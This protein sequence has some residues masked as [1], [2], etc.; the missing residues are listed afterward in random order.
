MNYK[1]LDGLAHPP[2]P[3]QMEVIM[4]DA[5]LTVCIA[6]PGSGKTQT[7]AWRIQ[8][9]IED[10]T[11]PHRIVVLTFT[12]DAAAEINKRIGIKLGYVGTLHGYVLRLLMCHGS[13]IGFPPQLTILDEEESE[14]FL[15]HQL[16]TMNL[17]KVP[18]KELREAI[19]K[20]PNKTAGINDITL[21]VN[22]YYQKMQQSGTL[23][24]DSMLVFGDKLMAELLKRGIALGAHLVVDESQDSGDMD[25]AIYRKSTFSH[26]TFVGDPDQNIFSFR[27]AN[28]TQ[29]L[30][31]TKVDGA[32]VIAL[33]ESFRSDRDICAAAN[34]LIAHNKQ[35]VAKLTLSVSTIDGEF[36]L[37]DP[38]ESGV[39]EARWLAQD[40]STLT[41][42]LPSH[43]RQVA[44]LCRTNHLVDE[45]SL[46][47][48]AAGIP[49]AKKS[50]PKLPDDWNV[51]RLFL[52]LM[53]NPD[54]D[55][56]AKK[57]MALGKSEAAVA[58]CEKFALTSLT[59]INAA[60]L[61]FTI[62]ALLDV[63]ALMRKHGISEESIGLAHDSMKQLPDESTVHDLSLAL[64]NAWALT[65][66]QGDGVTVSTIH[67]AK[68]REWDVVYLPAFEES[69]IPGTRKNVD[70]EEERRLAF[71]AV[72]RARHRLTITW[73]KKRVPAYGPRTPE[74][75]KLSRYAEEMV[76]AQ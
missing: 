72:T 70:Y 66:E 41:D 17:K 28:L 9:I 25:F 49:V 22:G 58:E 53:C 1:F 64:V 35:R 18:K 47:L 32:N 21:A 67:S 65:E 10:S 75:A 63:P 74:P 43:L 2:T 52:S 11:P 37:R 51:C 68:G 16:R 42:N 12:N 30:A 24:Y 39:V 38:F 76:G 62:P 34:K 15:Q 27:G 26:K 50:A 13:I 33:E 7:M 69:V 19:A 6:G 56:L 55:Y 61:H 23:D 59:S 3:K 40:I 73:C 14:A 44:V 71:V 46:A 8:R 20:G 54:N 29:L 5:K 57:W 60:H 36:I 45:F 4:S 31:L 48:Q